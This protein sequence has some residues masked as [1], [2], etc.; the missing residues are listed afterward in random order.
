[1]R[2]EEI[3]NYLRA[4]PFRP[5]LVRVADGREYR[6]DHPEFMAISPS[7]RSV[8]VYG[9]DDLADIIDT[10]MITSLHISNGKTRRKKRT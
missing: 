9:H 6:V 8:A 4:E 1:M 2:I 3:R 7:G 5:F 10:L